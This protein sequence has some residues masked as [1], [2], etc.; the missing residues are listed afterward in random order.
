MGEV[1]GPRD[2]A[3]GR[4]I[5]EHYRR[6]RNRGPLLEAS[7]RGNADNPLCGDHVRFAIRT[8][9]ERITAARFEA[10]AC[11]ICTAAASLLSEMVHGLTLAEAAVLPVARLHAALA[12]EIRPARERCATLPLD[13]LRS[14]VRAATAKEHGTD[15][16]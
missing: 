15:G 12:T 1:G 14:A 16:E 3:Y 4:V 8:V 6:P 10:E 11:A 13:A 7:G 9:G 2:T 5:L